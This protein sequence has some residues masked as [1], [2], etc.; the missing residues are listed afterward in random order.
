MKSDQDVMWQASDKF[1]NCERFRDVWALALSFGR[2]MVYRWGIPKSTHC[3]HTTHGF[4]LGSFDIPLQPKVISLT[5]RIYRS[6][7]QWRCYYDLGQHIPLAMS[8]L[9]NVSGW[10]GLWRITT[11]PC[12]SS[13]RLFFWENRGVMIPSMPRRLRLTQAGPFGIVDDAVGE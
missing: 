2:W 8:I 5:S 10:R 4:M 7:N 3:L 1:F 6:R 9:A 13:S 11:R 12:L